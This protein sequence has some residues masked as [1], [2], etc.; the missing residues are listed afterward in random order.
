MTYESGEVMALLGDQEKAL[1]YYK[2]VYQADINYRDV[3]Q[4][5]ETR[6]RNRLFSPSL[7]LLLLLDCGDLF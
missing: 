2:Q 5:V 3:A 1:E 6:T 4:K 7:D